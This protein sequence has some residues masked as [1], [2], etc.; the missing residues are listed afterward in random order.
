MAQQL[1]EGKTFKNIDFDTQPLERGDYEFCKFLN[2]NFAAADL[3]S[4][5]FIES[6]FQ[7]KGVASILLSAIIEYYVQQII[8]KLSHNGDLK[9]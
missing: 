5:K 2:C 3:S 4:F 1:I 9:I 8:R 6:E 7:Q